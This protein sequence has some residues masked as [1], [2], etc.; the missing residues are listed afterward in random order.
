MG[1]FGL[2]VCPVITKLAHAHPS[3]AGV[4]VRVSMIAEQRYRRPR[5]PGSQS[6]IYKGVLLDGKL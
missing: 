5:A 2:G 1:P 4:T 6:G 3:I